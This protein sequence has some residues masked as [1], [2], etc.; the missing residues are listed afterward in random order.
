M[1]AV[2]SAALMP[3]WWM[4]AGI[5]V[6]ALHYIEPDLRGDERLRLRDGAALGHQGE[7]P[8][9]ASGLLLAGLL[10]AFMSTFSAT[11]TP[12]APTSSTTSTSATS[13]SPRPRATTSR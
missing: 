9:A 11:L 3:R 6:L 2:V 5:T 13:R 1:S 12:E 10:A 4:I 7:D 8:A